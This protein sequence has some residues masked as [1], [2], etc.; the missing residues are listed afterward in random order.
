MFN[1]ALLINT[2]AD[3]RGQKAYELLRAKFKDNAGMIATVDQYEAQFREAVKK[4]QT[5]RAA[6]SR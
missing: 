4:A 2:L 6:G 1:N 3:P 5:A